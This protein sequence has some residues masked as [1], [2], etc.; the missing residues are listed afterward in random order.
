M[1]AQMHKGRVLRAAG[2]LMMANLISVV[3]NYIR[4]ILLAYYFGQTAITDAFT[5]AFF[6]PDNVFRILVGG[7]LA[8]A[9]IPVFSSYI[10]KED[11]DN[12]WQ[13]SS[14]MLNWVMLIMLVVLSFCM[15][16]TPQV[17]H[18][19]V[20]GIEEMYPEAMQLTITLTRIMLLQPLF[21]GLAGISMGVL[22]SYQNF[23]APAIGLLAYNII[24]VLLGALLVRPLESLWPGMGIVAF[25]VGVTFGSVIYFIAQIPAL[26]KIN[27]KYEL[28]FDTGH[29]GF[30]RLIYLMVPLLISLSAQSINAG[31]NMHLASFLE[32]GSATALRLGAK[33]MNVPITIFAINIA[34]ATFPT[35][36][37]QAAENDMA[38]FKKSFSLAIRTIT[39]ICLPAAV[40]LM[41]LREPIIRLMFE[42][43]GDFTAADTIVT[44]QALFYYCIG[45]VF[46]AQVNVLLRGFYALH[47]TKIPV[48]VTVVCIISNIILSLALVG[49]MGFRG[50]ALAFSLAEVIR[51]LLLIVLLRWRLG[52]MDLRNIA[53]S[54]A[55]TALVCLPM[56]LACWGL[57]RWLENAV[58]MA[59]KANQLWTFIL[60]AVVAGL[61]FFIGTYILKMQEVHILVNMLKR[62]LGRKK[63]VVGVGQGGE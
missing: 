35:L 59:Y 44:A 36:T 18:I 8:S 33:L 43:G 53:V 62:R 39:F 32:G 28:N 13:V 40:G 26:R 47:N 46:A 60:C 22:H 63:P 19:L 3:L 25:A 14:I 15:V 29:P 37:R 30:R 21:M 27:F 4:E 2:F 12:A 5:Y 61:I 24:A 16:F 50:L 34:I 45:L 56:G 1:S 54:A 48:A 17:L 58:D 20:P 38:E 52:S 11:N 57:M 7:A 10:V 41:L 49:P 9:F 51:C 23:A 6:I 31:V 55:K 42:T